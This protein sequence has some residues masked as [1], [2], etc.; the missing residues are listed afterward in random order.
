MGKAMDVQ[1]IIIWI[2][3]GAFAG[4]IATIAVARTGR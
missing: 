3:V 4:W 1:I 2:I